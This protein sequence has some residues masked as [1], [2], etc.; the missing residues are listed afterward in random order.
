MYPS[1][2]STIRVS[3]TVVRPVVGGSGAYAGARGSAETTHLPDG[4]WK[5][6]FRLTP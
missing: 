3:D 6:V 2:G 5:H 4:S 1:E